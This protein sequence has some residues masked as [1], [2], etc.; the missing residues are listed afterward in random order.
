[1]SSN[2]KENGGMTI[3]G[4]L[5]IE[6]RLIERMIK[7]IEAEIKRITGSGTVD[8]TLI[9]VTA[10]FF[11]FYA[12]RCHHGKEEDILFRELGNKGMS[13]EHNKMMQE[14]L[15][16]HI[17]GR[18]IIR[19]LKE[20]GGTY[21]EGDRAAA[22]ITKSLLGELVN[23]YPR[24]IKKEDREFFVLAMRYFSD[25]EK[26]MMLQ[27]AYAFDRKLVHEKYAGIIE[28]YENTERFGK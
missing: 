16:E 13:D 18:A 26:N 12:D 8:G 7:I 9:G 6:H 14:L 27:E 21:A 1:M 5:M 28:R 17:Q 3:I 23:I 10:D 19:K 25:G 20:A 15:D 11:G 22:E 4:L 24:H 2:N